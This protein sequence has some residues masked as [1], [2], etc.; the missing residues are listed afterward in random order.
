MS[1]HFARLAKKVDYKY[2][3]EGGDKLYQENLKIN[4]LK[5]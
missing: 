3:C 1:K 4:N 2:F 5:P